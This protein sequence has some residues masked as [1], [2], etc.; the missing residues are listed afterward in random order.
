MKEKDTADHGVVA[1]ICDG[2]PSLGPSLFFVPKWQCP[3]AGD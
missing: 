2:E 3:A 1:L